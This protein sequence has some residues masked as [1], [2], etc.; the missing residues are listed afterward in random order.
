VAGQSGGLEQVADGG[1]ADA[2]GS[3]HTS[4]TDPAAT[5]VRPR[6]RGTPRPVGAVSP[7]GS[8]GGSPRSALLR[9]ARLLDLESQGRVETHRRAGAEELGLERTPDA[10]WVAVAP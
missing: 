7:A 4:H 9:R 2:G 10:R 8:A 5:G 6:A 3:G 1:D